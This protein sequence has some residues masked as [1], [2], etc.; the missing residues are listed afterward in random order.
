MYK[1]ESKIQKNCKKRT[2]LSPKYQKND[3]Y[4]QNLIKNTKKFTNLSQK[5]KK[6][7]NLGQNTKK[8]KFE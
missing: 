6:I 1:I 5:Y 8:Y 4:A 2:N 7:T 3:N